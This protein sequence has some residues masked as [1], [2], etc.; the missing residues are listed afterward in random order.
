MVYFRASHGILVVL[1]SLCWSLGFCQKLTTSSKAGRSFSAPNLGLNSPVGKLIKIHG[2]YPE[3]K[4]SS[5]LELFVSWSPNLR[6]DWAEQRGYPRLGVSLM[7]LGFGN[8]EVLGKAVGLIPMVEY[9]DAGSFLFISTGVGRFSRPYDSVAPSGQSCFW[10]QICQSI[11]DIH[12]LSLA[13]RRF[14]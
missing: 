3:N 11:H 7:S 5:A 4:T 2:E 1:F 6:E 14:H 8:R 13:N 12:G 10:I 9:V